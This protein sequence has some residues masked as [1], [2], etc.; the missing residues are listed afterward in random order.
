LK[1]EIRTSQK[2]QCACIREANRLIQRN[3]IITDYYHMKDIKTE[4][5]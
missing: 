5:T 3:K 4:S 1:N 2:A